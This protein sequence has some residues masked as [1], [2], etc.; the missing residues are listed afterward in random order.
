MSGEA[1][2]NKVGLKHEALTEKII[3]VFYTVYNEL[4]HGFLESVCEEAM[5]VCFRESG[6]RTTRQTAVPVW[7]HGEKVGEFR[8][9]FVIENL[10]LLE[11]KAVQGLDAAH[12]AQIINYLNATEFEVGLLLNFGP[13]PEIQRRMLDN[14]RKKTITLAKNASQGA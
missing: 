14:D 5:S 11:I 13:K 10:V 9:D 1:L 4:G 2:V 8:A 6:I 7:F 12:H 3:R